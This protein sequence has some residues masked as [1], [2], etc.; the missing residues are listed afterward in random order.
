MKNISTISNEQ[1]LWK[2]FKQGDEHAFSELYRLNINALYSYGKKL[3]FDEKVVED[4]IQ[5]LF[6]ELWQRR[7]FLSDVESPRFYMFRALRRKIF[8]SRNLSEGIE[9]ALDN[10]CEINLPIAFSKEF[11]IIE[12]EEQ[13]QLETE[14]GLWLKNL[15]S[16]QYEVL[17]LRYYQDFTYSQI[18]AMLNINEQSVRNILQRALSR[19]RQLSFISFTI[20]LFHFF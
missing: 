5:D 6:I 20:A 2:S 1:S 8:K 18:S 17:I 16:R 3:I 10:T 9:E 11:E 15:P 7:E 13:K 14:I 12:E 4:H 19:L